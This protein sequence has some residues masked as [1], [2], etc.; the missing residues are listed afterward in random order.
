LVLAGAWFAAL[1]MTKVYGPWDSS[2][3]QSSAGLTIAVLIWGGI[4]SLQRGPAFETHQTRPPYVPEA[5]AARVRWGLTHAARVA[6]PFSLY[7]LIA[8][9]ARG[10]SSAPQYGLSAGGIIA[11]YWLAAVGAGVLL[12]LLKPFLR[13]RLGSFVVGAIMGCGVYGT[14]S[15]ALPFPIRE[16][17]VVPIFLGVMIGGGLGLVEY[18]EQ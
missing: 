3:W 1:L 6:I 15:L 11:A 9:V 14:V 10:T 2:D 16:T 12:G 4:R 18:D 17:W 5:T 13:Y 7:V 8:A